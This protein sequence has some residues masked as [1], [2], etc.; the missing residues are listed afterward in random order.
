M[1]NKDNVISMEDYKKKLVHEAYMVDRIPADLADDPQYC[2]YRPGSAPHPTR[3]EM[4]RLIEAS[5]PIRIRV[6]APQ[7]KPWYHWYTQ[8]R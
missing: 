1:N 8:Q 4:I 6:K 7:P 2:E 5:P 3:E